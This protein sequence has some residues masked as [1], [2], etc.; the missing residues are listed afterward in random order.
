MLG[1]WQRCWPR[2]GPCGD[3]RLFAVPGCS[4]CPELSW[5]D[6]LVMA[7]DVCC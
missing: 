1:S 3:N 6:P 2:R 4:S 5:I 7:M